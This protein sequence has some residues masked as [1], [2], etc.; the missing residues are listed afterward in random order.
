MALVLPRGAPGVMGAGEEFSAGEI[1]GSELLVAV[2][3]ILPG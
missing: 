3:K 2:M 1:F